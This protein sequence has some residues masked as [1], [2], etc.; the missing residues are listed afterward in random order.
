MPIRAVRSL[1]PFALV[2]LAV[3]GCSNGAITVVPPSSTAVAESGA[4]RDLTAARSNPVEDRYYPQRGEPYLDTLH[5]GLRL[6]WKPSTKILTGTARIT[7]R[8]TENRHEVAFDLGD[9]MKVSSVTVDGRKVTAKQGNN[10]LRLSATVDAGRDHTAVVTYSGTPKPVPAP[11]DRTDTG[12]GHGLRVTPRGGL[13]T[14]QEP[15]GAF[16]WYPVN[17]QPADKA[18]YDATLVSHEG[19]RGVFN[20]LLTD[21]ATRDGTTTS[22]FRLDKP[23]ASYLTTVAFGDYTLERGKLSD[24]R[25]ALYWWDGESNLA[26][27]KPEVRKTPQM[28]AYLETLLGPYP[29]ASAGV[30]TVPGQSA[31]ETQTMVTFGAQNRFD[32]GAVE[33]TLAHEQAHQWLGDLVTPQH[34]DDLWLNESLTMFVQTKYEDHAGLHSYASSIAYYRPLERKARAEAGPPGAY[35]K[36]K[37][38]DSNVYLAGPLMLDAMATAYGPKFWAGLKSWPTSKPSGTVTRDDFIKHFSTAVGVDLRPWVTKWLTSQTTPTE[39]PPSA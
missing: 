11:G 2:G 13:W 17:D 26:E 36:D 39:A 32:R 24:G 10:S 16:T 3:A 22:S 14:M 9:P 31:M 12:D 8:V 20:G 29:Y 19:Q 37:F 38:A 34:W 4:G 30:L 15:H 27:I 6:D 1:V 5:Y 25:P 33:G 21:S 7:F 35:R 23:A 18:F 28:I